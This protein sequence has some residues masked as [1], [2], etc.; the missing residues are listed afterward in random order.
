MLSSTSIASTGGSTGGVD[1]DG[2]SAEGSAGRSVMVLLSAV[3]VPRASDVLPD[4]TT[5][6]VLMLDTRESSLK[7]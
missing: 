7:H 3:I 4:V 2:A 5:H 1:P 6:Q